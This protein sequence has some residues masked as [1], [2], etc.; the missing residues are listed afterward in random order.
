VWALSSGMD[1]VAP[2]ERVR[3]QVPAGSFFRFGY[4]SFDGPDPEH[5]DLLLEPPAAIEMARWLHGVL[6]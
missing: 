5:A 2:P 4:L 6:R 1:N 3:P